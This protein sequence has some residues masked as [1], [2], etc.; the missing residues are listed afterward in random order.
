MKICFLKTVKVDDSRDMLFASKNCKLNKHLFFH[1][2]DLI[3]GDGKSQFLDTRHSHLSISVMTIF[4]DDVFI[5]SFI[6]IATFLAQYLFLKSLYGYT[7][8]IY[9]EEF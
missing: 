9:F 3:A 4:N 2:H 5:E 8:A 1:G 7:S 6:V